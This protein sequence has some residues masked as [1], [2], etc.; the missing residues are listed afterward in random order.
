MEEPRRAGDRTGRDLRDD[1]AGLQPRLRHPPDDQLRSRRDLH[2]RRLHLILLRGRIREERLPRQQPHPRATHRD[3]GG[4]RQQCRD[5]CPPGTPGV[6]TPAERATARAAHHRDR[7]FTLHPERLSGVL[8]RSA[9][10]LSAAGRARRDHLDPRC[11]GPTRVLPGARGRHHVD[12]RSSG[13]R[14]SDPDRPI[15]A[16][17]RRGSSRSRA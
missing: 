5:G 2:G 11:R 6:P 1:R 4:D 15:D 17:R 10:W 7:S 12:A 13:V 8:R 14:R 16:R 9:A 3:R